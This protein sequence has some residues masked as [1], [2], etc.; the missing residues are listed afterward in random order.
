MTP[1]KKVSPIAVGLEA[2]AGLIGLRPRTLRKFARERRLAS[3]KLGGKL[4]F[5]ISELER[6]LDR[7]QK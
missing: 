7:N 1:D 3:S 6:F 2:A 4:V 5:R